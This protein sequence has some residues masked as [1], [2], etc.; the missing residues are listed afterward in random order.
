MRKRSIRTVTNGWKKNR[1][2]WRVK[3]KLF[4]TL[5]AGT[6]CSPKSHITWLCHIG[7]ITFIWRRCKKSMF[8][9]SWGGVCCCFGWHKVSRSNVILLA[10]Y[11]DA[12]VNHVGI[13]AFQKVIKWSQ[14]SCIRLQHKSSWVDSE[15]VNSTLPDSYFFPEHFTH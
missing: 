4:L 10:N 2:W 1:S 14:H 7:N 13:W 9:N 11:W 3:W 12:V 5:A 15:R 6:T 8:F